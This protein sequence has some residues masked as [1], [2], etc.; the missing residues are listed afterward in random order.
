MK[1]V[2]WLELEG[3]LSPIAKERNASCEI[4]SFASAAFS[5]K[6]LVSQLRYPTE[7]LPRADS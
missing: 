1:I 7:Y 5:G 3:A 6:F 4:Q 2:L